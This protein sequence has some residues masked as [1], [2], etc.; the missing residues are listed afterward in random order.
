MVG[1]GF[2]NLR[3][4]SIMKTILACVATALIVGATTATA[5]SLITSKDIQDGSIQNR[6]IRPAVLTMSR[7]AP[8]TQ[9]L[10]RE[11]GSGGGGAPGP[12]GEK[13]DK[14]ATG[15]DGAKGATGS[16]GEK[17]DTGA[18]GSTGATGPEG[19]RGP[20]STYVTSRYAQ[21]ASSEA[22]R[23]YQIQCPGGQTAVGG[24]AEISP[25]DSIHVAI[26][27]SFTLT[28][29][30]GYQIRAVEVTPTSASWHIV[31]YITCAR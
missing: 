22:H 16:K 13:G 11:K 9:K 18:K 6:D 2:R 20:G 25:S 31:G 15:D 23:S 28:S 21:A 26:T 4:A 10:I 24:G 17:G 19:P 12:Q 27:A 29:G 1:D 3:G 8:T 30:R 14:G 5:A 7:L